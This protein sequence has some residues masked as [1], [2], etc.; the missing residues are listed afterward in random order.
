MNTFYQ[1]YQ[2]KD[3]YYPFIKQYRLGQITWVT[4]YVTLYNLHSRFVVIVHD[5]SLLKRFL[6]FS[7]S[8]IHSFYMPLYF[9]EQVQHPTKVQAGPTCT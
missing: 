8:S 9:H 3:I 4:S 2:C 6:M 5:L 7:E 1:D